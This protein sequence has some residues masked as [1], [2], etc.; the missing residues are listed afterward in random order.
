M[1]DV[2]RAPTLTTPS[3]W[4]WFIFAIALLL[5]LLQIHT[6]ALNHDVAYFLL[7]ARALANG[8]VLYQT[9]ADF[10]M[11][12]NAWLGLFSLHIAQLLG[13]TLAT[14]HQAVLFVGV[15]ACA[16]LLGWIIQQMA[17]GKGTVT[18][19]APGLA[20]TTLL[21]LPGYHFGQREVLLVAG[22]GPWVVVLAGRQLGWR[23]SWRL[24][25]VVSV[26]CAASA[27]LKPHFLVLG[28]GVVALDLLLNRGR[29]SRLPREVW[30]FTAL[31]ALNLGAMA[32]LYP[33]YYSE[34]LPTAMRT[35]AM[36]G[37]SVVGLWLG[38]DRL[39]AKVSLL[40]YCTG[41][42]IQWFTTDQDRRQQRLEVAAAGLALLAMAWFM[43]LVQGQGFAYH[44]EVMIGA[45]TLANG[46][47]LAAAW[48]RVP[49]LA[50]AGS[51][52]LRPL[53]VGLAM[54]F[55]SGGL[56][57]R[58]A[59]NDGPHTYA[60]RADPLTR[61]LMDAGPRAKV[62]AL[63][64]GVPPFSLV[65]AYANFHWTGAFA[66]LVEMRA[67]ADD[68][69]QA[70]R[71]GVPQDPVLVRAEARLRKLALLSLTDP[72]PDLVFVDVSQPLRWF[73][74]FPE[75]M[76]ILDFLMEDP[77]FAEAWGR[78]EKLTSFTSYKRFPMVVYRLR[79]AGH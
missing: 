77:L 44:L 79:G 64:T 22:A 55:A 42:G 39:F 28:A 59:A 17:Q 21:I 76:R 3:R 65:H 50:A 12:A 49:Q 16:G 47:W 27:S 5:A 4:G 23:P 30:M 2:D 52:W 13:I 24:S 41:I 48:D 33:V 10:N 8:R 11:P 29:L 51:R 54:V 36:K 62:L 73:E 32:L 38:T 15:A 61:A 25:F 18:L 34:V 71:E 74:T 7:A 31:T 63:Q 70:A 69:M 9:F 78:Y 56:W 53:L 60:L 1:D 72:A 20:A 35:Y 26:L 40:L 68:R 66:C 37:N 75:P 58:F 67:I 19:L 43:F 57:H 46:L 45:A 6:L 14:A